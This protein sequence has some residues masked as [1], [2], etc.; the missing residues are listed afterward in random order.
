MNELCSLSA[1]EL[2]FRIRSR[3]VTSEAVVAACLQRIA[4]VNP[5]IN[6]VVQLVPDAL[7]RARQADADLAR[8]IVHGPL[9]GVPFT[10]KDVFDVAGVVSAV[11]LENRRHHVPKEDAI[12]VAR[13]KAAGAIL[14][15]KTNCPPGGGGGDTENVVYGRTLNPYDLACTPG[16][17]SGGEAAIIAAGGSPIGLGSD[18]GGSI[19]VPAHYCGVAGLKPSMGRVP[20]T[21][22]YDHPGGMSDPRSQVG[23]L[24][25]STADL[26]L[27]LPIIAGPDGF[28]SGVVPMPLGKPDDVCLKE[29]CVAYFLED[30]ASSVT[31]ETGDV[32]GAAAQA[33]SRAGVLM[34]PALPRDFV[35][36]GRDITKAWWEMAS[37]RGQD[38]VEMFGAWD[39]YRTRLLQFMQRYDAILCPVDPHPAPPFKERDPHR[40]DYT[41]P[42]SLTGYPC[43]VVRAGT[44]KHG[45]PIGVQIAARPWRDDVALALGQA[46]E[47]AL[48]GW[49]ASPTLGK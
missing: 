25:R 37:L 15:A 32:V 11:G 40:F 39:Q 36:D 33:L 35:R 1:T 19:R 23:P 16:G 13:L 12:A 22:A 31:A 10:A 45:M 34:E 38:V 29:L 28:D 20:N 18:S 48:G 21:G 5:K 26:A 7:D 46:I 17:S 4:V 14:M 41:L 42:F 27:V 47:Q 30:R 2:A 8:G 6:A 43:V 49:R 44:S 9:H 3:A 24:A